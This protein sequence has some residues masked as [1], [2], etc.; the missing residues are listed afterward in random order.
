MRATSGTI[1]VEARAN[2]RGR[3]GKAEAIK[4]LAGAVEGVG[5]VEVRA[6]RA[7]ERPPR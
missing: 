7:G 3:R 1:V 2:M 4:E 5:Y 6:A